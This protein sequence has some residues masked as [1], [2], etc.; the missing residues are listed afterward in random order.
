MAWEG[1][2]VVVISKF[3]ASASEILAGA[4][5]DYGRGLVVG[6]HSTHGK[7][8][9]QSLLDLGE[10]L[11]FRGFINPP[12]MGALKVTMQQFYRPNGESTQKRGVLADVELPSL[13]TH[14]PVGESDLDQALEW[15][16]VPKA[17]FQRLNLVDSGLIEQLR[18]QS[19][20]RVNGSTDFKKVL[21]D[22]GRYNKQKE[23]KSV[24][25]NEAKFLAERA[26][27]N[28]DQEEE[29]RIEELENS[30]ESIK[31]DYYLDEALAITVDMVQA[32]ERRQV[33][34]VN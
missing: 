26:E 30:D 27:L 17:G 9:V 13:T 29:D 1:P 19:L 16:Q 12:Q 22:V 33:A 18:K 32:L 25:L 21:D 3:S 2:L 24:T 23:Q 34:R 11:F 10:R 31:R 14:L 5:Q 8:T 4:I 6:D 28:A 20:A 7:G 15:N